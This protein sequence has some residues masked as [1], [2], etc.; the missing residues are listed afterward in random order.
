VEARGGFDIA[1]IATYTARDIGANGG[2]IA[3][4][5]AFLRGDRGIVL[6]NFGVVWHTF[7]RC[8]FELRTGDERAGG[9]DRKDAD[10]RK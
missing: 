5:D 9:Y 7:L 10:D 4:H 8:A 3:A 2:L 1:N 6:S